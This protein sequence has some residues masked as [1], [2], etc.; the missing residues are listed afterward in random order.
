MRK[1]IKLAG[2]GG[3]GIIV[4]G[5]LLAHAAGYYEGKEV[6]QTQSYGPEARGGA[7]RA[8]VVI[9]DESIDYIKTLNPDIFVAM[10]QPAFEKYVYGINPDTT[11]VFIDSDLVTK[12]PEEIKHVH[13]ISATKL[14]EE[15][16]S[17]K[18][19]ANTVM[20]GALL[21]S[22]NIVSVETMRSALAK[23]LPAKIKEINF[24]ALDLGLNYCEQ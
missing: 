10:S 7:C 23:Q 5:V 1:E 22:T 17:N 19:V 11:E 16:C 4:M 2:F 21:K 8:E 6:A 13:K 9:S 20:M 24:K 18:M 14:A 15:E 3:Q 12:V